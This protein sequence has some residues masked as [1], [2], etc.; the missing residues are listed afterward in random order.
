MVHDISHRL[1]HFFLGK[2]KNPLDF[3]PGHFSAT[4]KKGHPTGPTWTPGVACGPTQTKLELVLSL[5]ILGDPMTRHDRPRPA[6]MD[7]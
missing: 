1:L 6:T 5:E 2:T 3:P 4:F 7:S